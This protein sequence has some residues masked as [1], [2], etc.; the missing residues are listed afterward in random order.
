MIKEMT[1]S[2]SKII[3]VSYE[4]AFNLTFED[5][6]RRRPNIEKMAMDFNWKPKIKLVETIQS[7]INNYKVNV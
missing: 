5:M 7:L 1:K 4:K 2:Q 3:N 6:K